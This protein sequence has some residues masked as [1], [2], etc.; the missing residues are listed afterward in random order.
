[1][2]NQIFTYLKIHIT[3]LQQL[4]HHRRQRAHSLQLPERSTHLSNC[5]FLTRM[6]YKNSYYA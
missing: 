1:L 3:H 6:L 2:N 4:P 5:N